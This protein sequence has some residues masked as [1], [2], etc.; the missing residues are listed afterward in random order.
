M[1]PFKVKCASSVHSMRSGQSLSAS[2]RN[3]NHLRSPDA[4]GHPGPAFDEPIGKHVV[5][6]SARA[7]GIAEFEYPTRALCLLRFL[8]V[9]QSLYG[10]L[11]ATTSSETAG[12][13][14]RG[15]LQV[16]PIFE[17]PH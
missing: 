13:P 5:V 16:Q 17:F 12:R 1:L 3:K 15:L 14:E 2:Y 6:P 4:A 7:C 10:A 8:C 9:L 11:F